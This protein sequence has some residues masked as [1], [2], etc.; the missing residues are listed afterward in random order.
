M[1][2]FAVSTKFNAAG[3]ILN[4]ISKMDKGIKLFGDDATKSFRKASRGAAGFG[5]IVKGILAA[6][7]IKS[8]FRAL[9]NGLRTAATEFVSYDQA[10]V[11]A[12]AK[13][14]GLNTETKAGQ[15]TLQSLM[16]TARELGATT[17]FSATQA[18]QG[19]DFLAMAGFTAEQAIASLPGVVD[20]ATVAG[21]DLARATDIASDSLGAFGLMSKKTAQLQKNFT[22]INDVFAKT[23]V[24]SNTNMEALFESVVKG[25]SQFT[26]SGQSLETFAALA[27]V[28]ANAGLKGSESG[29]TLRNMMLS[30]SKVAPASGKLL[31]DL[32]VKVKDDLTGG[33]RDAIDI[34]ADFEVGLKSL[35]PVQ[36]SS[37]L[38]TIF[39][40][41]TVNGLNILLKEG[42][43]SLRTYRDDLVKAGGASKT[44]S[45][46]IR[47]SL[48][49]QLASLKSASLEL[50]FQ[51]IDTFKDKIGPA[52]TSL[53]NAIRA[54]NIPKLTEDFKAFIDTASRFRGILFGIAAGW[55]A[56]KVGM[57]AVAIGQAIK[58]FI[59]FTKAL[60]GA[61][62]AQGL[63]NAVMMAN[64]IGAIA[65]AIG[66]L[67]GGLFLLVDNFDVVSKAFMSA[68]DFM[69]RGVMGILN[70]LLNPFTALKNGISA[71]A[72]FVSG[73]GGEASAGSIA[74]NQSTLAAQ[75]VN[76]NGQLNIAGAP[77]GST[78]E[79]STSGAPAIKMSLAGA[80]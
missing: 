16:D 80:N 11:S 39:G 1:P 76:F 40:S 26:T 57:A 50:G 56:F 79:S 10:I 14:K 24:T 22:R 42:S 68:M 59:F 6:D 53:T 2:D 46:K 20:L 78:V 8:G 41:R 31:K 70:V 62:A 4:K 44:M 12:S 69:A 7:I 19:L 27:G 9:Q 33:F 21:T 49:N 60:Q 45:D 18:A 28:M 73:N 3:N 75:E 54:I 35:D 29:T 48:G 71:I 74:P 32:G 72:R 23:M 51:F 36:R 65:V 43:T 30:L 17:E 55:T 13:F 52:I 25:G 58:S 34:L 15:K 38:A 5:S 64:P 66:L 37:A 63:L 47:Q 61:A 67:V 77:E